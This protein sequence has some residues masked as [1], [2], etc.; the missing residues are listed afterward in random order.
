MNVRN[1][2]TFTM[3]LNLFYGAWYF[4]APNHAAEVYGLASVS[5]PL[6]QWLLQFFGIM[7]LG[8]GVMC[9]IVRNA[10]KSTGRTAVLAFIATTGILCFY[11]DVKVLIGEPGMMDYIDTVL[12]GILGFGAL[13]F[14]V[15]DRKTA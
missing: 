2:L 6:S 14:I 15:H 1:F 9:A 8:A 10:E 13:Y 11:M 5:T 3:I 4:L 12:N 7:S